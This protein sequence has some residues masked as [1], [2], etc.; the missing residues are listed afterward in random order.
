MLSP[1]A[2]IMR[3]VEE[4]GLVLGAPGRDRRGGGD[5]GVRQ[6]TF[7]RRDDGTELS[8]ALNVYR[9]A[10]ERAV[11]DLDLAAGRSAITPEILALPYRWD[12]TTAVRDIH[13]ATLL[14]RLPGNASPFEFVSPVDAAGSR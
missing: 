5:H 13:Q 3:D 11:F 10:V 2:P 9:R 6:I 7:Q 4:L 14:A 8:T 1:Y 12:G